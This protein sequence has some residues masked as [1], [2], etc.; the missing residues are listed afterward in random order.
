VIR[1]LEEH[2][3]AAVADLL[4][5]LQ[6]DAVHTEASIRHTIARAN[7]RAQL[8]DWVAEEGGAV[9][10]YATS[11][12]VWWRAGSAARAWI[13]VRQDARGR[14]LGTSLA[15]VV[16][17][18]VRRLAPASLITVSV[19]DDG[20]RFASARG[21]TVDRVD[22][23]SA[24]DPRSA[25]LSELPERRVA[26][27]SSGYRVVTPRDVDLRALYEAECE[28]ANDTPGATPT[29]VTFEEWL[30]D[31]SD[32]PTVSW[33]GSTIVVRDGAVVAECWLSVDTVNRR[34]RNELTG[35]VRAHRR[36]GLATLAKLATIAWARDNDVD[37]IVTDNA[38]TNE[39]MLAINERLGY[40]PFLERQ[41]WV[42][43]LG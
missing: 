5:S 42:K 25:D 37:E 26:A 4:R 30:H 33:E 29:V 41:R 17:E 18:H 20:G 21:F 2:D 32:H 35:T 12:A 7:P 27:E 15:R 13:G 38:E 34:G 16:S 14:G 23:V 8:R 6:P 3:H 40:R 28:I 43:K 31:A 19:E 24:L 11:T 10:G 22:V 39:G 9:V 36:R 1:A